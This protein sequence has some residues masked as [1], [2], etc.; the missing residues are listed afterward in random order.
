MFSLPVAKL[1]GKGFFLV[2]DS[3]LQLFLHET[4]TCLFQESGVVSVM[5]LRDVKKGKTRIEFFETSV[6]PPRW[7]WMK[8]SETY[9]CN[10]R[11]VTTFATR[12]R[13]RQF[14]A[15]RHITSHFDERFKMPFCR[16]DV[17]WKIKSP[18]FFMQ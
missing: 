9:F 8:F 15:S 6:A 3:I 14:L 7:R 1:Q 2:K 18:A 5:V 16:C 10:S 11:R 12:S 4:L 17:F 13:D